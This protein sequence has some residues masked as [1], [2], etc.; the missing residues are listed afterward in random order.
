MYGRIER[1]EMMGNMIRK[2]KGFGL[3]MLAAAA[4]S[5]FFSMDAQAAPSKKTVT[6][7]Y[8]KY[9]SEN[10]ITKYKQVDIDG[11]GIRELLY[12]DVSWNVGVCTYNSKKKK[13]VKIKSVAVGK[14]EP[15]IYYNKS[16][17][18]FFLIHADTGGYECYA[19]RL[20]G[21]KKTTKRK[22]LYTNGKFKK[23]RYKINGKKVSQDKFLDILNDYYK[24]KSVN[25]SY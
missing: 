3:L 8:K 16:K 11:N 15:K 10:S 9:V 21:T 6:K 2:L 13:V 22:M 1:R 7:A 24:W 17:K 12:R 19:I 14:A 18:S 20:K 4:V 5:L 25:F 23:V